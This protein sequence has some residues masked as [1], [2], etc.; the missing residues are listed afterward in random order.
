MA[1]FLRNIL[2][3]SVFWLVFVFMT[4][5]SFR[6]V[7]KQY[8]LK[9][10][11]TNIYKIGKIKVLFSFYDRKKG[12]I[13]KYVFWLNIVFHIINIVFLSTFIIYILMQ[14]QLIN[15]LNLVFLFLPLILIMVTGGFNVYYDNT[16]KKNKTDN[17]N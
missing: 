7:D 1:P 12:E 16:N 14:T 9:Y 17:K 11:L 8:K 10:L 2:L 6:T 13:A 15:I 4:L 5:G 3:G